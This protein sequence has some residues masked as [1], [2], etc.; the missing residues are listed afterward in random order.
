MDLL[1]KG[2]AKFHD[3]IGIGSRDLDNQKGPSI[4]PT[5]DQIQS[6]G[7]EQELTF[8]P[9]EV[10]RSSEFNDNFDQ[11]Y[12]K[13]ILVP[14]KMIIGAQVATSTYSLIAKGKKKLVTIPKPH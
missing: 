12:N 8:A 13:P 4:L 6:V 2:E 11:I 3:F 9:G 5:T 1:D 10:V 7:A 14:F